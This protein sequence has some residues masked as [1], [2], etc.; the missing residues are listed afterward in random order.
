MKT[1]KIVNI[2]LAL[3]D[4][5]LDL[6]GLQKLA[7]NSTPEEVFVSNKARRIRCAQSSS[8]P[9]SAALEFSNFPRICLSNSSW[10][11]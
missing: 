9:G 10:F 11:C 6:S 3:A 1:E 4:F 2:E 8:Q 7:L 5:S